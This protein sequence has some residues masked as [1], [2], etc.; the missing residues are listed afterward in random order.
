MREVFLGSTAVLELACAALWLIDD[1][2][3]RQHPKAREVRS[4]LIKAVSEVCLSEGYTKEEIKMFFKEQ[5][6][7][8]PMALLESVLEEFETTQS[9]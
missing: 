2:K 6:T 1:M 4:R 8:V 7:T 3:I 5:M 9:N